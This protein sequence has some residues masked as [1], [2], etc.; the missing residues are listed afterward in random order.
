MTQLKFHKF[1]MTKTD[2]DEVRISFCVKYL[3][4]TDIIVEAFKAGK[5]A[6]EGSLASGLMGFISVVSKI[7]S[8]IKAGRA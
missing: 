7:Y 2:G 6:I 1:D 5:S 8:M 3:N 4:G